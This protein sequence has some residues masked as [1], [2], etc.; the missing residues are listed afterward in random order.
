M[1]SVLTFEEGSNGELTVNYLK[2]V[3]LLLSLV[4]AVRECNIEKHLH[5]E[6]VK[7][8]KQ[9][10][11]GYGIDPFSNDAPRHLPTGKIIEAT[12][13]SDIIR[14]A[15]LG[16]SQYKAF[17]NDRL[18]KG[19]VTFYIPTKKNKLNT[20]IQKMKRSR[21]TEDILKEYCQAIGTIIAKA[22]NLD[23]TFQYPIIS[24]PLSIATI[25]GD[26]PQFEK[27]SLRNFLINN[28][29][30][31]TNCIPE[32]ASWFMDGL[33]AVQSLKSKDTYGEWIESLI[34]FITPPKLAKC[35]LFGTVNDTY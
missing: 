3:S 34:R 33:S 17:I 6:H 14:V 24:I 9:K 19:T 28:S 18:I 7:N 35:L 26:L 16:L 2:D 22:L 29:I 4:F 10:L 20:G 8:L 11:S 12:I 27:A 21:K 1:Q 23:E 32:K 5:V 31:T 13:V 30:A 15:E 25:D